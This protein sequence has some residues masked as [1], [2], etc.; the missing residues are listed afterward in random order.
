M[1]KFTTILRAGA[2]LGGV[3]A[4]VAG[5]TF[6]AA[7][8]SSATLADNLITSA[9]TTLLVDGPDVD[10]TFNVSEPGFTF[11]NLLPGATD[12]SDG[13]QFSLKNDGTTGL[14][15]G[16]AVT[17][18]TG[19]LD[20]AKVHLKFTNTSEVSSTPAEYT[21]DQL[22]TAKDVPGVSGTDQLD[23]DDPETTPANESETDNFTVQVK[24]DEG[25]TS[26]LS[27]F[28][29]VFTGTAVEETE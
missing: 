4:L 23:G 29:L 5:V 27:G 25:A 14:K 20:P 7:P 12:Y 13:Q 19:T 10:T 24:L 8:Q 1:K 6:A 18:G 26:D 21:L 9:T 16:V 17:G 3:S 2:V 28:S 22:V 11:H 15:V